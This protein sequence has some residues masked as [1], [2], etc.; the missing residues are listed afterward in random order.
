MNAQPAWKSPTAAAPVAS[1]TIAT[2][3]W[4]AADRD[5]PLAV[6]IGELSAVSVRRGPEHVFS[7]CK[8]LSA[9][10]VMFVLVSPASP[11]PSV[12]ASRR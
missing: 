1:P 7:S 4:R 3:S 11:L 8:I 12:A 10:S 9:P 6:A 2:P 5:D